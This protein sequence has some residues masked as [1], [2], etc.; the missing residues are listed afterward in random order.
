MLSFADAAGDLPAA[1][2]AADG[3]EPAAQTHAEAA[4]ST[5]GGQTEGEPQTHGQTHGQTHRQT[6]GQT[7]GIRGR[8]F[9]NNNSV[10]E[11][12]CHDCALP[13]SWMTNGPP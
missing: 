11:A 3:A 7:Q 8:L 5:A 4:S 13:S 10:S 12:G 1:G 9:T 6:H 2:G